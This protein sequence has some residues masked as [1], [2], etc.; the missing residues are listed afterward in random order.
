MIFDV[1][2]RGGKLLTGGVRGGVVHPTV[3]YNPPSDADIGRHVACEQIVAVYPV[4]TWPTRSRWR[5]PSNS[6]S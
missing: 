3:S 4:D 1:I 2:E 6:A 5:T